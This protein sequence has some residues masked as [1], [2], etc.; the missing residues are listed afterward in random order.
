MG[1]VA[2]SLVNVRPN[3]DRRGVRI[4]DRDIDRIRLLGRWYTLSPAHLA[5]REQDPAIWH[6]DHPNSV[7]PAAAEQWARAV[8]NVRHRLTRLKQITSDPARKIGPFVG[9]DIGNNS[10]TTWFA[11]PI[12]ATAAALPWTLRHT[13]NPLSTAHAWMAADIGMPLEALGLTVV[14]EREITTGVNHRGDPLPNS[15]ASLHFTKNGSQVRKIPDLAILGPNGHIAIEVERETSRNLNVY[16]DK[17]AAYERN[18]TV[19]A[20]WYICARQSIANRVGNAAGSVFGTTS[21]FPLRVSIAKTTET[22][23]TP[24]N[25]IGRKATVVDLANLIGVD[26]LEGLIGTRAL[27]NIVDSQT[28]AQLRPVAPT[29]PRGT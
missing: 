4:T 19:A 23:Y 20:V 21:T 22:G 9:A 14:S 12:G 11:T 3:G 18:P 25:P 5:R 2:S 27:T 29:T 16:R 26:A 10:K 1:R 8:D 24:F 17:L 13:I 28:L 7:T 6:P 15:L